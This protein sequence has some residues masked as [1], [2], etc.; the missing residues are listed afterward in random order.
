MVVQQKKSVDLS[1]SSLRK[2][3]VSKYYS[4]FKVDYPNDKLAI[5]LVLLKRSLNKYSPYLLLEAIDIFI[6]STTVQKCSIL[7]FLSNDFFI[8][9]F[10]ELIIINNII[11]YKRFLPFYHNPDAVDSLIQEYT[12]YVNALSLSQ[13]ELN[14]KEEILRLLG[15]IDAERIRATNIISNEEPEAI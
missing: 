3:F 7:Y 9:K 2:Y 11:K 14:R 6:K 8:S 10:H 4:K 12:S 13:E 15:E 1:C 5:E